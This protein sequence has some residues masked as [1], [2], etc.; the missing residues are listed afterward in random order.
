[1]NTVQR[2]NRIYLGDSII[3][4]IVLDIANQTCVFKINGA[5]VLKDSSNPSIFDPQERYAP[6]YLGFEG[7]RSI[8]CLEGAYCL[9]ATIVDFDA[10]AEEGGDLISFR[11]TMTG[12]YDNDTFMRSLILVARDFSLDSVH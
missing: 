11:L 2:F 6:A 12:G 1:M 7:V 10:V 9:N 8:S 4:Q 5:L 3:E